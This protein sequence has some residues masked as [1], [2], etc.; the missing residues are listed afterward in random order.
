MS[1]RTSQA[2]LILKLKSADEDKYTRLR[3]A[4]DGFGF[5][6]PPATPDKLLPKE[7]FLDGHLVWNFRVH[8]PRNREEETACKFRGTQYVPGKEGKL[9]EMERFAAVPGHENDKTPRPASLSCFVIEGWAKG[10]DVIDPQT[11]DL[12]LTVPLVATTNPR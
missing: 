2:D 6:A 9:V 4:P 10:S 11:G 3:Y 1:A 8:V 7:M 5:D 12:H